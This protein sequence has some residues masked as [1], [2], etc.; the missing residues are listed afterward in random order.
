MYEKQSVVAYNIGYTHSKCESTL[1]T[2]CVC[3]LQCTTGKL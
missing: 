1:T 2:T 3:I